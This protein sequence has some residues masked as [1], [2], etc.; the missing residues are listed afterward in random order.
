MS[1]QGIVQAA[2]T[3]GELSPS[4]WGRVDFN[5]Y[6]SGAK[7]LRNF[8][9][10][11]QGGASNRPGSK[12]VTETKFSA[13]DAVKMIPFQFSPTQSYILEF[14]ELYMRVIMNGGYVLSGG[15]PVEIATIFHASDL[16]LI[17]FTQSFDVMTLTHPSYPVQQ[18]SRLSHTSWTF[19]PFNNVHG[20]FR[21]INIDKTLTIHA[22]GVVGAV[23]LT[24]DLDT[25]TSD[26]VG[27]M[28]YIEQNPDY[29]I[30]KWQ[31]QAAITINSKARSGQNYYQAVSTGTTGTTPPSTLEG[32]EYDGSPGV[33]WQYL[34][35]GFGILLITGFTDT[36]HIQGTVLSRLP[37]SLVTANYTKPI[38]AAVSAGSGY[39]YV[40]CAGHGFTSGQ[41]VAISGVLGMTD[42]NGTWTLDQGTAIFG[43]GFLW[44]A[45]HFVVKLTTAQIYTSGGSAVMSAYAMPAYKWALEAWGSTDQYPGTVAYFQQR[46]IFAGSPGRPQ[47]FWLSTSAGYT[48]Y[49]QSVPLQ[50]NDGYNYTIATKGLEEIRHLVDLTKL[51]MFTSGGVWVV[52]GNSDGTLIPSATSAKRQINDG[53]N[54][55]APLVIGSEALFVLDKGTQIKSVGYNWQKDTFLGNDLTVMSNHLFENNQIIAWAFQKVPYSCVWA[56]RDDGVLLSLTYLVEQDVIAWCP[57]D[58][59]GFYEDVCVVTEGQEDALYVTVRRNIGGVDHRFIERFQSRLFKDPTDAFFVDCGLTYSGAPATIISG[60]DH[61]DGKTVSILADGCI[62][63]QLVVAGGSITLDAPASKVQ[64]GLPYC[65]TLETLDLSVPQGDT[66]VHQKNVNQVT[67]LVQET[68]V[69]HAGPSVDRLIPFRTPPPV[70]YGA[71]IALVTDQAQIRIASSWSKGGNVVIQ[72]SDPL[73]ITILALV[74]SVTVGGS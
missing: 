21:D 30:S 5:K 3:A 51:L 40:T 14:G 10:R 35:S 73:P 55:L 64:V 36:K 9:I 26:M 49:A 39:V 38:T 68:A 37:D 59:D 12:L 54:H 11:Q 41:S 50:D 7:M 17:K 23:N 8:F 34:H 45:N 24:A 22:D 61:L 56:V 62:R 19:A 15:V 66:V 2:F 48:D 60:L 28:L 72:Q 57:H 53:A 67:A 71:P 4:L 29:G 70:N 44:D 46:Q 16:A 32:T 69:V 31:V 13:V 74:P 27:L 6:Y 52:N 58:T 63:P 20:P 47:T 43:L 33:G 18:L 65:S 1:G 42:L 25:F